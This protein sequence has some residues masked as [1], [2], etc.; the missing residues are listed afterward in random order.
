MPNL[1]PLDLAHQKAMRK[2]DRQHKKCRKFGRNARKCAKYRQ[3]VGK[4]NGPGQAGRHN[5]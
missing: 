3:R 4:P 2:K 1:S 5:H